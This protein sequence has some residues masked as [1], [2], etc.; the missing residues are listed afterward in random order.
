ML[1]ARKLYAFVHS[2]QRACASWKFYCA[3]TEIGRI[4]FDPEQARGR[5]SGTM[6]SVQICRCLR[7]LWD[8]PT[9]CGGHPSH[10][11]MLTSSRV[12]PTRQHVCGTCREEDKYVYVYTACVYCS[13][14]QYYT[15]G[16]CHVLSLFAQHVLLQVFFMDAILQ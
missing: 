16:A 6:Q 8:T 5:R 12:P 4:T 11:I 7:L 1:V 14:E 10:W 9:T 2:P 15:Y 13:R 3:R